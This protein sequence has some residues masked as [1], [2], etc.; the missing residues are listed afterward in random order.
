MKNKTILVIV[1]IMVITAL[2]GFVIFQ[3]LIKTEET[4]EEEDVLSDELN[5]YNW[6]DYF[7]KDV[8]KEFEKEY[9]VRVNLET[10][11]DEDKMLSSV[12]SDLSKYDV[13]IAS[14]TIVEEM[15]SLK[16]LAELDFENI[17][18]YKYINDNFK[19]LPYDSENKYS[20]PYL[21]GTTGI[22]VN[23]G[24]VKDDINSWESLWDPKYK[25]KIAML[26]NQREVIGSALKM[27]GYS[28]NSQSV[29]EIYEVRDKLLEQKPLLEGYLGPTEIDEKM[30]SGEVVISQVYSGDVYNMAEKYDLDV[31]YI[32]PSEGTVVWI[33]NMIVPREAKHKYTAEVFINYILRP[34]VSAENTNYNWYASPS[35]AAREFIDKEIL[36]DKNIYPNEEVMEKLEKFSGVEEAYSEYNRIWAELQK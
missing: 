12:Q 14:G 6:E 25:G 29:E 23:R 4:V 35:D 34:E 13:A 32:I 7:G 11:N 9:G 1:V 15:V 19:N 5:V 24:M 21:W 30:D 36:E 17:P 26:N 18:N 20:V 3:T 31:E 2:I 16:L 8:I 27:L 33:D 10:Y 28:I 22:V